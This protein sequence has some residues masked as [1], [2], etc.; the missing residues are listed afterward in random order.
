VRWAADQLRAIL[1]EHAVDI[2]ENVATTSGCQWSSVAKNAAMSRATSCGSSP[3]AK[4]PPLG[5][6]LQRRMLY[7]R[8]AHSRGGW[9]SDTNMCGK[10]ATAVGTRNGS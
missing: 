7:S 2:P 10:T 4:C 5:I 8:S 1:A 6:T 3:G 9:P